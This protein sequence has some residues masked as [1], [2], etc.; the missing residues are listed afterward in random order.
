MPIDILFST[1]FY[2]ATQ[3]RKVHNLKHDM[4]SVM[5]AEFRGTE[6]A[7]GWNPSQMLWE[8]IWND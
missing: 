5:K 1:L 4:L 3:Q 6:D 2:D 7:V 8:L